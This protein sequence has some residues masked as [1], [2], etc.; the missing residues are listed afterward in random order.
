MIRVAVTA[1]AFDAVAATLPLGSGG[2]E[3]QFDAQGQR[4]GKPTSTA[5]RENTR[6]SSALPRHRDCQLLRLSLLGLRERFGW[7]NLFRRRRT[8]MATLR[9]L[10]GLRPLIVRQANQ[11][12][13]PDHALNVS[14]VGLGAGPLIRQIHCSGNRHPPVLNVDI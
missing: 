5:S 4:T 10:F 14:R 2:H 3:A 7:L 9:H 13:D 11:I 6:R 8:S 12:G 1:P